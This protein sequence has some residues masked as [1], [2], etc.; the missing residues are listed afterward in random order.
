[1]GE[2]PHILRIAEPIPQKTNVT[3]EKDSHREYNKHKVPSNFFVKKKISPLPPHDYPVFRTETF[4]TSKIDFFTV[5]TN[6]DNSGI[7]T[8]ISFLNGL[9]QEEQGIT[10][11]K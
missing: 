6:K 8:V 10:D 3:M 5:E 4:I 1:M 11:I 9:V 2:V 7:R